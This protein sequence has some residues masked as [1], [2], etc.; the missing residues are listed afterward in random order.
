MF[1]SCFWWSVVAQSTTLKPVV[2]NLWAMAHRWA[3]E[4]F[5]CE[6]QSILV[7]KSRICTMSCLLIWFESLQKVAVNDELTVFF[8][9]FFWK[10]DH[11]FSAGKTVW[12]L[13]KTFFLE[14]TWFWQKNRLNLIQD[15]WKFGSS[16]F[17]H[18][19]SFQKS[20]PPPPLRNPGYTTAQDSGK[21]QLSNTYITLRIGP[22][23]IFQNENG[24]RLEKGW[25][26]LP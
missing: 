25:K 7:W 8:L 13:V 26:P 10:G 24:P 1:V 17:T 19:S 5:C 9:F 12:I 4:V 11:L 20:T 21:S 15:W 2:F 23:K 18:V 14:I 3:A 16:S 22:W 6:P